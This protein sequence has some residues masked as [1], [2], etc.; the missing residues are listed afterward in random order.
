MNEVNS[1]EFVTSF[2]IEKEGVNVKEST[3]NTL[4]LPDVVP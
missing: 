2:T 4:P 3:S 1:E